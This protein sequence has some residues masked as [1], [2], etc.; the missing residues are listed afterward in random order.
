MSRIVRTLPLLTSLFAVLPAHA[1]P[2][3]IN[4]ADATTLAQALNGVGESKALAIVDY[5]DRHGPF[6]SAEELRGTADA[7]ATSTYAEAYDR[8]ADFY[9]FTRSLEAYEKAMDPGTMFIL[10]TDSEFLKFLEKPR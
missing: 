4:R 10:G 1:D 5:R 2:V 9:A 8:D 6:R 3:D 7:E